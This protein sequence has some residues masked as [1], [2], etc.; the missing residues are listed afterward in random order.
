M[1][2]VVN[3]ST[4]TQVKFIL[5]E[6]GT[7][8]YTYFVY[9]KIREWSIVVLF[10][11]F[12]ERWQENINNIK[13]GWMWILPY[14][15]SAILIVRSYHF[16][17]STKDMILQMIA[18]CCLPFVL[19]LVCFGLWSIIKGIFEMIFTDGHID[20]RGNIT[21]TGGPISGLFAVV[22][23][24]ALISD[25]FKSNNSTVK[26]IRNILFYCAVAIA[27]IILIY[28]LVGVIAQVIRCWWGTLIVCA[29]FIVITICVFG[30]NN[31]GERNLS[32][33]Q[34]TME[35]DGSNVS[36]SI[37]TCENARV[38]VESYRTNKKSGIGERIYKDIEW[39]GETGDITLNIENTKK[40]DRIVITSE[41]NPNHVLMV[42]F[43]IMNCATEYSTEFIVGR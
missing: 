12:V 21:L 18:L 2:K 15:C 9:Y 11:L 10:D 30:L 3:K 43:M 5:T 36:F 19:F 20:S 17:D 14:W 27:A 37:K 7:M 16:Y 41:Y 34:I 26:M 23:L 28:I 25:F 13:I 24:G 39:L 6:F 42:Y 32:D 40:N 38:T 35:K 31:A 8:E 4:E 29:V 33:T 1:L 22:F